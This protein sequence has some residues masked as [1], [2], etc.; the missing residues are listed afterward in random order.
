MQYIIIIEQRRT[1]IISI[2]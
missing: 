1:A 2:L